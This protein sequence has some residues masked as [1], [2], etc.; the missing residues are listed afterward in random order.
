MKPARVHTREREQTY[1][2]VASTTSLRRWVDNV[3]VLTKEYCWENL[4]WIALAQDMRSNIAEFCG[5]PFSS[6]TSSSS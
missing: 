5:D 1:T 4:N 2:N 6:V 3:M